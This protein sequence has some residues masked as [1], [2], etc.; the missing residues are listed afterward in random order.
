MLADNLT[1]Y[2]TRMMAGEGLLRIGHLWFGDDKYTTVSG[3]YYFANKNVTSALP[4]RAESAIAFSSSRPPV[5]TVQ[6]DVVIHYRKFASHLQQLAAMLQVAPVLPVINPVA[7]AITQCIQ[8]NRSLYDAYG[9]NSENLCKDTASKDSVFQAYA[10]VPVHMHIDAVSIKSVG[11]RDLSLMIRATRVLTAN[12]YGESVKY[13]KSI[14]DAYRQQEYIQAFKNSS[15]D[16]DQVIMIARM[17]GL[18]TDEMEQ[19]IRAMSAAPRGQTQEDAEV[20]F[21]V[22]EVVDG[23]TVK[24]AIIRGENE[25]RE[26]MTV[27]LF[28]IDAPESDGYVERYDPDRK[29]GYSPQPFSHEARSYLSR[30]IFGDGDGTEGTQRIVLRPYE[31]DSYGRTVGELFDLSGQNLNLAMVTA[32]LAHAYTYS[33]GTVS[34]ALLEPYYEAEDDARASG[35][36]LWVL[37]DPVLPETFRQEL[38][39]TAATMYRN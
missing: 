16:N 35:K 36:G 24:G 23:D 11:P 9:F 2:V 25:A 7:A 1:P 17:L 20:V 3:I 37:P 6:F 33:A 12:A 28:G 34:D 39:D 30:L 27:R 22:S 18:H 31:K 14:D 38:R 4:I 13:V 26:N 15:G 8:H 5:D 32:G 10:S 29:T 19:M 21:E